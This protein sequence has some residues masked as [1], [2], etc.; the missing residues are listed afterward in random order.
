MS[1]VQPTARHAGGTRML[2]QDRACLIAP[3]EYCSAAWQGPIAAQPGPP[4][5]PAT[6]DPGRHHCQEAPS[7]KFIDAA[8][9]RPTDPGGACT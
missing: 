4:R 2:R 6:D 8:A 3:T 9:S 7:M 5:Q 1:S